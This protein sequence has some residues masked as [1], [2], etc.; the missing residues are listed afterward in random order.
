MSGLR[1]AGGRVSFSPDYP[2]YS[3]NS[4]SGENHINGLAEYL[5]RDSVH[6]LMAFGH[7]HTYQW[8][9]GTTDLDLLRNLYTTG[10][11]TVNGATPGVVTGVGTTFVADQVQ[12]GDLYKLSADADSAYTPVDTVD[13]NTQ[14]TLTIA[15]AGTPAGPAN[16]S[17]DR[18]Q[19]GTIHDLFSFV[20]IQ[21]EIIWSQGEDVLRRY[22]GTTI[23][24]LTN[25][26]AAKYLTSDDARLVLA[27]TKE[28]GTIIPHRIRW[29]VRGD[30]T[31]FS[32]LGSGFLDLSDTPDHIKNLGS[33]QG[34][35]VVYKER[36]IYVGQLTG[37]VFLPYYFGDP[38]V[39]GTGLRCPHSLASDGE[40]H[41]FV[42]TDDIYMFDTVSLKSITQPFTQTQALGRTGVSRLRRSFFSAINFDRA[43]LVFGFVDK[44]RKEYV[45]FFALQG[46]DL[47]N[48]AVVY[49]YEEDV[50][51]NEPYLESYAPRVAAVWASTT[52]TTID[53]LVGTIDAQVGTIN[54]FTTNAGDRTVLVG[55]S[56]VQGT[57]F[58]IRSQ[59]NATADSANN[60]PGSAASV[61]QITLHE[62]HF[63]AVGKWK[64]LTQV[65]FRFRTFNATTLT[66]AV[67]PQGLAEVVDLVSLA[68]TNG[69]WK[70]GIAHFWLFGETFTLRFA[71]TRNGSLLELGLDLEYEFLL[72]GDIQ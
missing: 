21:D 59:D 4:E 35:L 39:A 49:N 31:D 30:M 24:N 6:R 70:N 67:T 29:T 7:R 64:T 5:R 20:T 44:E 45:L 22:D 53:Q 12:P 32:G 41:F 8:N 47:P 72:R 40:R 10:T 66:V 60:S 61:G 36:N 54:S 51:S 3:E 2:L 18:L 46:A 43:D 26:V 11:S 56:D 57:T 68:D 17:V 48:Q 34:Q 52:F 16:Y 9:S 33:I 23:S 63:G 58:D 13:S 14:L 37:N 25:A 55:F 27:H 28:S 69:V 62:D 71:S 1:T 38:K 42:G 15:Y 65:R 19:T 50:W